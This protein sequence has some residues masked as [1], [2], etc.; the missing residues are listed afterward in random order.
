MS[1]RPYYLITHIIDCDGYTS[2]IDYL[3]VN[4]VAAIDRFK[5]LASE[6]RRRYFIDEGIE[7]DRIYYGNGQ[8]WED[9]LTLA[10]EDLNELGKAFTIFMNDD[11]CCW[12]NVKISVIETGEFFHYPPQGRWDTGQTVW[13]DNL[14]RE[15]QY[16]EA[17][18]NAKY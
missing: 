7:T 10:P 17:H 11:N 4:A 2:Y 16:K 8:E 6:I 5:H 9:V 1:K 13:C 18:P 14:N 3:G 12:V 15:A